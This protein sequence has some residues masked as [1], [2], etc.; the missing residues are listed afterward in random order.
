MLRRVNCRPQYRPSAKVLALLEF[1]EA[2][3]AKD[4]RLKT[5][6]FSQWT[7]M[8]NIIEVGGRFAQLV[9]TLMATFPMLTVLVILRLTKLAAVR[10][11]AD[12]PAR[13]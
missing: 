5:V 12:V 6:V 13:A 1:L 4:R 10:W 9:A 2:T 3:R 7:T 8:L 11:H